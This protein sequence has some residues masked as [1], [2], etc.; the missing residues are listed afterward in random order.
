M[1]S[2]E[3]KS[4]GALKVGYDADIIIFDE[5]INMQSVIVGGKVHNE[6]GRE[7]TC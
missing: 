4:K 6:I 3:S 7:I 1:Q 2:Y 5:N